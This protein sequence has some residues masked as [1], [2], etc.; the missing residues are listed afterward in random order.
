MKKLQYPQCP[1]CGKKVNP[2]LAFTLKNQ[3]EYRCTKCSGISNIALDGAVYKLAVSMV[4]AAAAVFLVEELL[5]R[6]FLWYSALLVLLPFLIFYVLSP[7]FLELKRPV[8]KRR[9]MERRVPNSTTGGLYE[10]PYGTP[11]RRAD[12]PTV[13]VPSTFGHSIIQPQADEDPAVE[14]PTIPVSSFVGGRPRPPFPQED[15]FSAEVGRF[16]LR[17]SVKQFEEN[18]GENAEPVFYTRPKGGSP[19][20]G[21]FRAYRPPLDDRQE[22]G[23]A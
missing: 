11:G 12:D 23:H 16:G 6:R 22:D 19:Q 7:L 14:E 15:D 20:R 18:L 21:G 9:R 1:Y 5:V 4:L 10:G 8:I 17:K 13:Y 3:G 2:L